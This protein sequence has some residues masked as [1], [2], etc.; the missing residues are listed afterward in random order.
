[1]SLASIYPGN[2]KFMIGFIKRDPPVLYCTYL[3]GG[4]QEPVP[5]APLDEDPLSEGDVSLPAVSLVARL[6]AGET[7]VAD[8]EVFKVLA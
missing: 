7:H 4:S 1:M 6:C 3:P 5:V 8:R 2:S